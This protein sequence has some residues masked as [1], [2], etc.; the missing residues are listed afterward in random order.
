MSPSQGR[1]G[2]MRLESTALMSNPRESPH[3]VLIHEQPAAQVT[4]L[5]T[6]NQSQTLLCFY[7]MHNPGFK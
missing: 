1:H 2:V 7:L 3:T 6:K 5:D 4:H